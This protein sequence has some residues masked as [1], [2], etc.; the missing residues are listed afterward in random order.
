MPDGQLV[1]R[2]T[3]RPRSALNWLAIQTVLALSEVLWFRMTTN[4]LLP[5]SPYTLL[6]SGDAIMKREIL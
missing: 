1:R 5:M 4:L 2:D 3:Q 6:G